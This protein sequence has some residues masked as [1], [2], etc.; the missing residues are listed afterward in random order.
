MIEPSIVTALGALVSNRVYPDV[1]PAGVALPYITYQ[2]VGGEAVSFIEA[3][4]PSKKNARIQ[5]N[6]WSTTRS[7]A[8]NL[9]RD[10]E[11][12]LILATLYGEPQ[13]AAV[14]RYD[15]DAKLYG[16]MQD[17]SFWFDD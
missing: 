3:T 6:V 13:G 1:A 8:M 5:I 2:Q 14:A 10:A 16:A 12:T 9:I 7:E 17:F 15:E 4:K 11:D